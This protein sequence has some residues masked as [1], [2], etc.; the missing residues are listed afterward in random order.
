MN[1][2]IDGCNKKINTR[3][4]GGYGVYFLNENIEHISE[5]FIIEPVSNDRAILYAIYT[6][7]EKFI[8][9]DYDTLNINIQSNHI[10]KTLKKSKIN[11]VKTD[12]DIFKLIFDEIKKTTKKII[13][14]DIELGTDN[15][16]DELCISHA[17]KLASDGA[18]KGINFFENMDKKRKIRERKIIK[19]T[20]IQKYTY[21]EDNK[22]Y[23][24]SD[25][26][27]IKKERKKKIKINI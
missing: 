20:A 5:P 27:V 14:N 7:I 6:I 16:T 13:F 2:Y 4:Y 15:E 11:R 17:K 26:K 3:N 21:D 8:V 12:R 24:P 22:D 25:I 18:D 23:K 19:N 10:V 9:S 1:V